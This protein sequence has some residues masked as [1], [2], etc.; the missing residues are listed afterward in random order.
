MARTAKHSQTLTKLRRGYFPIIIISDTHF[1]KRQ[2]LAR[3]LYEFLSWVDYSLLIKNGDI[4]DG[5]YIEDLPYKPISEWEKRVLDIQTA[6]RF[7][8]KEEIQIPGN[9]DHRFRKINGLF[10][11]PIP[12]GESD[13]GIIFK[14]EHLLDLMEYPQVRI[15][16]GD[17]HD[18]HLLKYLKER[19]KYHIG[20]KIVIEARELGLSLHQSATQLSHGLLG[21]HFSVVDAFKH[22]ANR[23]PNLLLKK[24][25]GFISRYQDVVKEAVKNSDYS[26]EI[27]GHIHKLY[28]EYFRDETT[29][30]RLM[31]A[32]SGDWSESGSALG[33]DEDGFIHT[34]DWYRMRLKLGFRNLPRITDENPFRKYRPFTEQQIEFIRSIWP[35]AVKNNLKRK[36]ENRDRRPGI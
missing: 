10:Q 30:R 36:L 3:L 16:H 28:L 23:G 32:N 8:G 6:R 34:L 31:I 4:I 27:N 17:Q 7:E 11:Q 14:H 15:R 35:S 20:H 9:H 29:G 5:W 25:L 22:A 33:I 13:P 26:G 12:F 18:A 1:F 21:Q 2:N 19:P 24:Q